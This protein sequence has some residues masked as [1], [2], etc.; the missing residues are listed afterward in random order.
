MM[1]IQ[2]A[3]AAIIVTAAMV[4][5]GT[6]WADHPIERTPIQRVADTLNP[7]RWKLPKFMKLPK[8][9]RILPPQEEPARIRK[10]DEGFMSGMGK[11]ASHG[12]D[13]TKDVLNPKNLSPA[14]LMPASAKQP[15]RPAE[16]K[17]PGFWSTL[18]APPEGPKRSDNV[19]DFLGQPKL[20][21]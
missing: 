8:F 16:P 17:K 4:W 6:T 2:S 5:P 13:R 15:S 11:T 10:R 19:V 21:R 12:W 7:T 9:G 3:C 1:R 18:L 14:R 20:G